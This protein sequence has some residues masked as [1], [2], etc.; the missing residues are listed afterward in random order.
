MTAHTV[1]VFGDHLDPASIEAIEWALWCVLDCSCGICNSRLDLPNWS[2]PPWNEDVQGWAKETAPIVQA[3]GW[4]MADDGFNLRCP[5][6]TALNLQ[7]PV[8]KPE[9]WR[10]LLGIRRIIGYIR[11]FRRSG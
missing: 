9:V 10:P 3:N 8:E 4:S 11:T 5:E 1:D 2:D 7:M 6:C